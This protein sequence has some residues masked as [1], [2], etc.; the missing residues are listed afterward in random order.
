MAMFDSTIV[1][2]ASPYKELALNCTSTTQ[3]CSIS[4]EIPSYANKTCALDCALYHHK[5]LSPD[6]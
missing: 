6:Y 3:S 5:V 2:C 4:V 1:F